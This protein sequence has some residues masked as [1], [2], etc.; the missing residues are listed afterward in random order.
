M[1]IRTRLTIQFTTIFALILILFSLTVYFYTALTRRN[2][3]YQELENRA[4]IVAHVYLDANQVSKAT[5]RRTLQKYYQ[6]LVSPRERSDSLRHPR[7]A[8]AGQNS[9]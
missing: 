3:F 8:Q 5:Y 2:S 4:N 7:R 6:T 9:T 1:K